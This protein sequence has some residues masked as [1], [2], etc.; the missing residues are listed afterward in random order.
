MQVLVEM[1][2]CQVRLENCQEVVL[3][4]V[5]VAVLFC[6]VSEVCI[7]QLVEKKIILYVMF[8]EVNVAVELVLLEQVLGNLL[9]NVIDFIFESGCI[10]LSV[11]VDQEYVMFKVLDI[12]SGI[13]DYVFLCIFE[14]F[15][16]LFCVNG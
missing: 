2:L 7:V 12:G 5:D 9:D 13:F 1:L 16:F 15:Y 6:C 8:I 14:C 11:E 3:I 10:M 4:V